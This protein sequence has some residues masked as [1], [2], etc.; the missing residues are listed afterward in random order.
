MAEVEQDEE[1][2][3]LPDSTKITMPLEVVDDEDEGFEA[4]D[5]SKEEPMISKD[6]GRDSGME[7]DLKPTVAT[8]KDEEI[9]SDLVSQ[10]PRKQQPVILP[11]VPHNDPVLLTEFKWSA[12]SP[13]SCTTNPVNPITFTA[14]IKR[15]ISCKLSDSPKPVV[16]KPISL[17]KQSNL[18][19]RV[20]IA[21]APS[22]A[23]GRLFVFAVTGPCRGSADHGANA[24]ANNA[25]NSTFVPRQSSCRLTS[26]QSPIV[27]HLNRSKTIRAYYQPEGN[28]VRCRTELTVPFSPSMTPRVS[29]LRH[30]LGY[31]AIEGAYSP[32]VRQLMSG[33]VAEIAA[34]II[35]EVVSSETRQP[36]APSCVFEVMRDLSQELKHDDS[37]VRSEHT[38]YD[39]ES[40]RPKSRN[41][42]EHHQ[43]PV[44]GERLPARSSD[45]SVNT[46]PTY[47]T[48]LFGGSSVLAKSTSIGRDSAVTSQPVITGLIPAIPFF[49]YFRSQL[50]RKNSAYRTLT[51]TRRFVI[52][53][54]EITTTS[55]RIIRVNDDNRKQREEELNKRKAELRAFRMLQ[56]QETRQTR[57]LTMMASQ[58]LELL[59]TKLSAEFMALQRNY[60]QELELVSKN[61]RAQM[62][63]LEKDH[64][65]ETK[66]LR[67]DHV[68]EVQQ[69]KNQL[70]SEIETYSRAERKAAKR[71]L[72]ADRE[73]STFGPSSWSVRS[74]PTYS[75][76]SGEKSDGLNI[77]KRLTVFREN[78]DTQLSD[79]ITRLIENYQRRLS[80][81]RAEELVEKQAVRMNFEQEKG[82]MDQR[83]MRLRH[84]LAR[85]RLQDFFT[86]KRQKL[87]GLLDLES[88]ELRQTVDREREQ[89]ATVHAIERKNH[90]KSAKIQSKKK[91]AE[92]QRRLRGEQTVLS[93]QFRERL[94]E[95]EDT[96][97]T[98]MLEEGFQLEQRQRC[99]Q[100]LLERS[101]SSRLRELDQNQVQKRNELLELEVERLHELDEKHDQEL[102][103]YMDSLPRNQALLRKQFSEERATNTQSNGGS[104][105]SDTSR[106]LGNNT[107]GNR[108]T[109]SFHT[110]VS[111]RSSKTRQGSSVLKIHS[112]SMSPVMHR[113]RSNK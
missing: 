96:V 86:I 64:E 81:L 51:R 108:Q 100:T 15:S 46:V 7:V 92:F 40:Y 29:Q 76:Q 105:F 54:K 107:H 55:K 59:E 34:Q 11:D 3:V 47:P 5:D 38:F 88:N 20:T 99:Q 41:T 111:D 74:S 79:R 33:F 78:Q 113:R 60:E 43:N 70:L 75:T 57:E 50:S 12:P 109:M 89:L 110:A 24:S 97:R 95:Y 80:I 17:T 4:E 71:E 72:Q 112:V 73:V 9:F 98:Q 13:R 66:K 69:F 106:A 21:H 68:K 85:N 16:T 48:T 65:A 104:C 19:R 6:D 42:E 10:H 83:H 56:K 37:V 103:A 90:A 58:R 14:P 27:I 84:Q 23:T 87:A 32:Q 26:T 49:V 102:R 31:Q 25:E 36:S 53:G 45:S 18:K 82:K 22:S 93:P 91:I 77:T 39:G 101:I 67:L 2:L 35:E 52:D 94:R 8:L 1:V 63:R 44:S 61:Y 30:R 62:E 28:P